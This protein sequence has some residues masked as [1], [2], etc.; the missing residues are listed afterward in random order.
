[1]H[2]TVWRG[3]IHHHSLSC[4]VR[5]DWR[6]PYSCRQSMNVSA[7]LQQSCAIPEAVARRA[8]GGLLPLEKSEASKRAAARAKKERAALD[9]S[10]KDANVTG[11]LVVATLTA[12]S[13]AVCKVRRWWCCQFAR[14]TSSPPPLASACAPL[15][16]AKVRQSGWGVTNLKEGPLSLSVFTMHQ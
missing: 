7:A 1:M 4:V 14:A 11:I 2:D 6:L 3:I 13:M 9:S 12:G 10:L 15:M 8:Q 16:V 5:C